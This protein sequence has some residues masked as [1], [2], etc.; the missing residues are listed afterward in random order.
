[1]TEELCKPA[2]RLHAII[3]A[4]AKVGV[5]FRRGPSRWWHILRWD[6]KTYRLES[7][8]WVKGVVYPRRSAI[9]ADGKLLCYFMLKGFDSRPENKWESFF[10]VSKI[11]W[12]TALAAWEVGSTWVTG[13][14]FERNGELTISALPHG[15]DKAFHGSYPG[16]V[17]RIPIWMD[18]DNAR[19][20]QEIK[21]G[22]KLIDDKWMKEFPEY[23]Q[24]ALPAGKQK[25]PKPYVGLMKR[26]GGDSVLLIQ[27]DRG[28]ESGL[29]EVEGTHA[30]EGHM[31]EYLVRYASG[32]VEHVPNLRWADWDHRGKLLVA[33]WSG[34]LCVYRVCEDET[35]ECIK[36]QDLNGM[37]RSQKKA[38]K[39][40]RRW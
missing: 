24:S 11:P 27:V 36:L 6:L 4:N 12:A 10:A 15:V 7:G 30:I 18:W 38:P 32:K 28:Y 29:H 25:L 9:S 3:A 22:W 1:M 21:T 31:P 16:K 34:E 14:W 33:T 40:A 8:A 37:E 26:R 13:C 19:F 35:L 17:N 39:L 20:I 5:V 23:L 2:C